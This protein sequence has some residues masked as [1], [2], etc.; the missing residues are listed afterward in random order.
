MTEWPFTH[1]GRSF[2]ENT[3]PSLVREMKRLADELKRYND[4]K[5]AQ[6]KSKE[7]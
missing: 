6:D 4:R 7:P 5:E 2:F 3:L 1:L